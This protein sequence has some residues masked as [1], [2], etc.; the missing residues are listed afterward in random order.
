MSSVPGTDLPSLQQ[1]ALRRVAGLVA[2]GA[3]PAELFAAVAHEV[4]QVTGS[5]LVQIQRFEP[6]DMHLS[7]VGWGGQN[8]ATG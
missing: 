8:S 2:A 7:S 1:A 3:P 6:D 4:A 5:A